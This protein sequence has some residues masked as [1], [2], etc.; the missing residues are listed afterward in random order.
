MPDEE[1]RQE[2]PRLH[3]RIKHVERELLIQAVRGIAD[4]SIDLKEK[5]SR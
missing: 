4:G 3:E 1:I 2:Q 5:A